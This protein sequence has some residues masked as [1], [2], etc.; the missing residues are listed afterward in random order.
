MEIHGRMQKVGVLEVNIQKSEYT[1][2]RGRYTGKWRKIKP[3]Q[4]T[5]VL[6]AK[7]FIGMESKKDI[8]W[9]KSY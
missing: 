4:R 5:Y 7:S 8:V 1:F 3:V 2:V 9:D 6:N